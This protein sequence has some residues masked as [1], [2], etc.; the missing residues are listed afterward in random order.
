V[1]EIGEKYYFEDLG[2]RHS[3]TGYRQSDIGKILENLVFLHL[4]TRGFDVTVG[5][6]G[7]KEID[8]VAEKSGER[9]YV[10]VAYLIPDQKAHDR[11]FGNLLSIADNYRKVVVSMDEP[12][13]DENYKGIEHVHIRKFLIR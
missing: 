10:Q 1:F 9:L 7:D 6:L 3:I 11:E 4:K 2:L 8:F 12:A 5:K 13:A